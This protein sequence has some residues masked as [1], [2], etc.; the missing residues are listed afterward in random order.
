ML[1]ENN[2][3]TG[4]LVDV[5][6]IA[7]LFQA[8]MH[9]IL[10]EVVCLHAIQDG[11]DLIQPEYVLSHVLNHFMQTQQPDSVNLNATSVQTDLLIT[12]R[13]HVSL[14]AQITLTQLQANQSLPMKTTAQRHA[15]SNVHFSL[16]YMVL[17]RQINVLKIAH[18]VHLGTMIQGFA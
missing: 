3:K 2:S 16:L 9:K 6:K 4:L 14:I 11:T 15:F 18:P 10:P 12:F 13:D 7:H 8:C 5:S 17:I 1:E